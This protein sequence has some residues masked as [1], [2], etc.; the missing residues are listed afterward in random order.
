M[1]SLLLVAAMGYFFAALHTHEHIAEDLAHLQGYPETVVE[2]TAS[3]HIVE[4]HHH[5]HE[6][7]CDGS[8]HFEHD[9]EHEHHPADHEAHEDHHECLICTVQSHF[10]ALLPPSD[11]SCSVAD[12]TGKD[13]FDYQSAC[14]NHAAL[15]PLK[16]RAPPIS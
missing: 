10:I 13:V 14:H 16:A 7:P 3:A 8:G 1:R 12:T 15:T 2:H 6:K 11:T 4:E 5:H 9:P